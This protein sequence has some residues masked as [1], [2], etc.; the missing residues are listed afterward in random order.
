MNA[1]QALRAVEAREQGVFD[2]PD[3]VAFGPLSC[4]TAM[5][6]L[7]IKRHCLESYG[8]II[9]PRDRRINRFYSGAWMVVEAHEES[10]L[11]TDDGRNGPWCVVGD[12]LPHLIQL[13]FDYVVGCDVDGSD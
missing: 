9:G 6:V 5:D 13:G 7:A 2:D 4:D 12:D 10:E 3:L 1:A 8:F 11:P